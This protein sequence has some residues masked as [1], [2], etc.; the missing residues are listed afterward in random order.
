MCN[1][2]LI[3]LKIRN[4]SPNLVL[5]GY[6]RFGSGVF[7]FEEQI[8]TEVLLHNNSPSDMT[9]DGIQATFN[10]SSFDN[11]LQIQEKVILTPYS[12]KKLKFMLPNN[13]ELSGFL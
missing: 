6:F 11:H 4:T 1:A 3:P 7:N 8:E 10:I 9:I 12:Q 13:S 5:S 2:S